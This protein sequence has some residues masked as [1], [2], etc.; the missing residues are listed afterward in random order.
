MKLAFLVLDQGNVAAQALLALQ[1][2]DQ[3]STAIGQ[4]F[5]YGD[6][7]GVPVSDHGSDWSDW[8]EQAG[9]E[10]LVCASHAQRL[11]IQENQLTSPWEIAGLGQWIKAVGTASEVWVFGDKRPPQRPLLTGAGA[12]GFVISSNQPDQASW[13]LNMAMAAAAYDQ[14]VAVIFKD[15]GCLLLENPPKELAV[16]AEL[17]V[18]DLFKVGSCSGMALQQIDLAEL[19][20]ILA[21]RLVIEV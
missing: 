12:F 10:I 21:D 16:L 7:A 1:A 4:V 19:P 18:K 9:V 15:D 8:A 2:I 13:L 5:L 3:P 11:G 17:G 20:Q 14:S 6:G